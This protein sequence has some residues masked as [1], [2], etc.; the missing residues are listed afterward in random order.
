ML[1]SLLVDRETVL[2]DLVNE[3]KLS[4]GEGERNGCV[5]AFVKY[6]ERFVWLAVDL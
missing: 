2:Y 6:K 4:G 5:E 1:D 3:V